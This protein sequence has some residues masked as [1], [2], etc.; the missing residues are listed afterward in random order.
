MVS[1]SY[2][3]HLLYHTSNGLGFCLPSLEELTSSEWFCQCSYG[4]LV[5]VTM[6]WHGLAWYQI[7]RGFLTKQILYPDKFCHHWS[8]FSPLMLRMIN[9]VLQIGLERLE[10]PNY[11]IPIWNSLDL[12]FVGIPYLHRLPMETL[13]CFGECVVMNFVHRTFSS[14]KEL[15]FCRGGG[16]IS[17][18]YTPTFHPPSQSQ[19]TVNQLEPSKK[20]KTMSHPKSSKIGLIWFHILFIVIYMCSLYII[21]L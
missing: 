21:F 15:C 10:D 16:G 17:Q 11:P 9:D 7:P 4:R 18:S 20:Q 5:T 2:I 6:N 13:S 14:P 1:V 12:L 3:T 19:P 8:E